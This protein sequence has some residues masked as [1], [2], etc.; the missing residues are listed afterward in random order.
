MADEA[1]EAALKKM[2]QVSVFVSLP[3]C[4]TSQ[5][6]VERVPSLLTDTSDASLR[7][8]PHTKSCLRLGLGWAAGPAP[9]H[10][11]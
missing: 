4:N 2:E 8:N 6:T 10:P 3:L 11:A 1:A 9:V 5:L 7:Y